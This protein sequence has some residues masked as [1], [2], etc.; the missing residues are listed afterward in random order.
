M[1]RCYAEVLTSDLIATK[2]EDHLQPHS[3][4]RG[5]FFETTLFLM[6]GFCFLLSLTLIPSKTLYSQVPS[7]K[8]WADWGWF[9]AWQ[10]SN[11]CIS[12][13]GQL[14]CQCPAIKIIIRNTNINT[15]LQSNPWEYIISM[16]CMRSWQIKF[17]KK[18][19]E[20]RAKEDRTPPKYKGILYCYWTWIKS[21]EDNVCWS[22][23]LLGDLY[24]FQ[25][26]F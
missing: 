17:G 1:T 9:A 12:G 25:K 15:P 5:I 21:N 26:T 18:M 16:H 4:W 23:L 6:P 22:F 13:C 19:V 7:P 24:A 14:C 2:V 20:L 8:T 3:C 11:H 10:V